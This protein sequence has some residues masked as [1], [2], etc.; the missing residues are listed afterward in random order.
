MFPLGP[1]SAGPVAQAPSPRPGCWF[2]GTNCYGFV[3]TLKFCCG[4]GTE[5]TER[6]GWCLGLWFA[7]PCRPELPQTPPGT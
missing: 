2:A 6:Y 1:A 7:P 4:D 5:Y 3:Q